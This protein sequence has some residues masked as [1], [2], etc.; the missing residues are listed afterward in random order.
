MTKKRFSDICAAAGVRWSHNPD[1]DT[2]DVDPPSGYVIADTGL[3]YLSHFMRGWT[4]AEAYQHIAAD[5]AGGI[6]K[7]EQAECDYCEKS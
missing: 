3:H 6:E 7:C 1:L 2:I 5:L 4:R